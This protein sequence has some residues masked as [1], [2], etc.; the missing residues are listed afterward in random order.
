[1]GEFVNI[2]IEPNL[3]SRLADSTMQL[4]GVVACVVPGA[5]GY[6]ALTCLY[7][8]TTEVRQNIEDLWSNWKDECDKEVEEGA[9]RA[10]TVRPLA[11][12]AASYGDGLRFVVHPAEADSDDD[13]VDSD[14]GAADDAPDNDCV[15]SSSF[16]SSAE[17]PAITTAAAAAVITRRLPL[18]V[19]DDAYALLLQRPV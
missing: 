3:Q 11:A 18:E 10:V 12:R 13:D 2:P 1:M 5:G 19:R 8:D 14:D 9:V 4:P 17:E 7:L 16:P 6:D 15:D